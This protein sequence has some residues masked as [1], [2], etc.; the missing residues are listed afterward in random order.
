MRP[1]VNRCAADMPSSSTVAPPTRYALLQKFFAREN[2]PYV[3]GEYTVLLR[4]CRCFLT[5]GTVLSRLSVPPVLCVLDS[6]RL[7]CGEVLWIASRLRSPLTVG[8]TRQ[9]KLLLSSICVHKRPTKYLGF[10][11]HFNHGY[12][13]WG[14]PT[15]PSQGFDDPPLCLEGAT[16]RRRPCIP[17]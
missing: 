13:T 15:V 17:A 14:L 8:L 6:R 3:H 7:G 4:T 9:W 1:E 11:V 10:M 2:F 5:S 16:A 12:D